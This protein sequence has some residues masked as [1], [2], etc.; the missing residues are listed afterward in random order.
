MDA[1]LASQVV[2]IRVVLT[3]KRGGSYKRLRFSLGNR[4]DGVVNT[5][6][7][8]VSQA[9]TARRLLQL[10]YGGMSSRCPRLLAKQGPGCGPHLF[11][12]I[13]GMGFGKITAP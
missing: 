10:I 11:M 9:G 2:P 6:A 12:I 5:Y 1:E 7:P 4:A 3:V 8:P 13:R